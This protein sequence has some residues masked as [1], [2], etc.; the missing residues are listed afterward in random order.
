MVLFNLPTVKHTER[1]SDHTWCLPQVGHFE[2]VT[3]QTGALIWTN[4]ASTS[5]IPAAIFIFFVSD[6]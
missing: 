2:L 1:I 5:F 6:V 4:L 3:G